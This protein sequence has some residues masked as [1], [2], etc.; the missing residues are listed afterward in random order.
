MIRIPVETDGR[1]Y[2]GQ[3]MGDANTNRASVNKLLE[4]AHH[5]ISGVLQSGYLSNGSGHRSSAILNGRKRIPLG[6]SHG[7]GD[8]AGKYL[9]E[10]ATRRRLSSAEEYRLADAARRGDPAARQSLIE[11]QLGLVV[12]MARRYRN[13]GLPL[14][15]LIAEGNMGLI[16]AVEKFDPERG[17]RFSTY[18]KWW[19]RQSIEL[20]LMTQTG[21]V[22]VPVYVMR[23]LKRK[24]RES[25][26]TAISR[27]VPA[28]ATRPPHDLPHRRILRDSA[29][30][31]LHDL[32][33][34]AENVA[35]ADA[36]GDAES[37]IDR[38]AA[39]EQDEPE[40][41]THLA[42]RRKQLQE[43]LL[44]LKANE[45]VIIRGRFGLGG[46]ETQTLESLARQLDL[47]SERV[48]QIQAGA[49][50]KLRDILRREPS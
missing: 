36:S 28:D 2:T 49:L 39:P 15:D 21:V 9:A 42:D 35:E 47:S 13:W 20:A 14:L 32:R 46:E 48:R 6:R 26:R 41:H 23:A 19:I 8:I 18:A 25:A 34:V 10:I 50:A 33:S 31:L 16:T 4:L 7:N 37:V 22:H 30:F 44:K 29:K 38:L 1:A 12:V 3:P 24:S 45:R 11:H 40:W 27:P 5:C 43:A 17:C